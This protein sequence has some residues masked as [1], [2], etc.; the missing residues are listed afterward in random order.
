MIPIPRPLWISIHQPWIRKRHVVLAF[1][2]ANRMASKTHET[3]HTPT[4]NWLLLPRHVQ[5]I[6]V[7]LV[8][9]P[10]VPLP[11]RSTE[12]AVANKELL[13]RK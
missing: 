12:I 1:D 4:N 10:R 7:S 8:W 13:K 9:N 6:I 5:A 11:S 3:G 2:Q